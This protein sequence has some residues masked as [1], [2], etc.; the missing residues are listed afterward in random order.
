MTVPVYC[1]VAGAQE[2]TVTAEFGPSLRWIIPAEL[3]LRQPGLVGVRHDGQRA[4][5]VDPQTSRLDP[6]LKW[7]AAP[8]E[9]WKPAYA[10]M[11]G[12]FL[13]TRAGGQMPW[14]PRSD[15]E[16]AECVASVL[17]F[18]L[19]HL[20]AGRET[21]R[22]LFGLDAA[23][24]LAPER[25]L[26]P[27]L[28]IRGTSGRRAQQDLWTATP[29]RWNGR[30]V[31]LVLA[32]SP[33]T[34][35]DGVR[36]TGLA[37][38]VPQGRRVWLWMP[39]FRRASGMR[40][41][42]AVA[43]NARWLIRELASRGEVAIMRASFWTLSLDPSRFAAVSFAPDLE[44]G[45]IIKREGGPMTYSYVS[46]IHG[47]E[48]NEVIADHSRRAG[49][50]DA[51]CTSVRC[52]EALE[53]LGLDDHIR[54]LFGTTPGEVSRAA[55]LRHQ[56]ETRIDE[57]EL[58]RSHSTADLARLLHVQARSSPF[59]RPAAALEAWSRILELE[60]RIAA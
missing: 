29:S 19:R 2:L 23:T 27:Y 53:R 18:E 22:I 32:I 44:D 30:E 5:L 41:G 49:N 9:G 10:E 7:H 40:S 55:R 58:V 17:D 43:H 6:V 25:L 42:A 31:D 14:P 4:V 48:A 51:F 47:W 54:S 38:M 56:V 36:I 24:S 37:R 3:A 11:R 1:H 16:A 39:E 34:L 45:R 15:G 12:R 35:R 52:R 28:M 33:A 60:A 21:D 46:N 59:L 26:A 50:I 57:I 8:D 20:D 13:G